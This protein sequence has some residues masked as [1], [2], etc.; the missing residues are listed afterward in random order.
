MA[1]PSQVPFVRRWI[2]RLSVGLKL[3]GAFALVAIVTV[4]LGFF[5]ISQFRELHSAATQLSQNARE[6]SLLGDLNTGVAD[7]QR[8]VNNHILETD[9]ANI[10]KLEAAIGTVRSLSRTRMEEYKGL[11]LEEVDQTLFKEVSTSFDAYEKSIQ[12]VLRY[13]QVNRNREAYR[14]LETETGALFDAL[15]TS[16]DKLLAHNVAANRLATEKSDSGFEGATRLNLTISFILSIVSLIVGFT[17][18]RQNTVRLRGVAQAAEGIARGELDQDVDETGSDEVADLARSF[19]EMVTSLREVATIA[20]QISEGN[21]VQNLEPKS[22]QDQFGVAISTMIIGLRSV[23]TRVRRATDGVNGGARQIAQVSVDLSKATEVQADRARDTSRLMREMAASLKS[24]NQSTQTL[25]RQ[26]ALVDEKSRSLGNA[27]E[28]TAGSL[29]SMAA[30]VESMATKSEL[31]SQA[32]EV[33]AEAASNGQSAIES[34]LEGLTSIDHTM[35]DIRTSIDAL[36]QRSQEIGNILN[37]INDIAEQ[38]NLLALNAAI[39]AARAGEAGRGFAV[40]ADEIRKLAER[41]GKST[42]EIETLVSQ[43]QQ[44]TAQAVGATEK[45]ESAVAT[46]LELGQKTGEALAR[47]LES[48]RNANTL[49]EDVV[50]GTRMQVTSSHDVVQLASQMARYNDEVQQALGTMSKETTQVARA[51]DEQ[52]RGIDRVVAAVQELSE[53]AEA[54]ANLTRQVEQISHELDSEASQL[55]ASTAFFKLERTGSAQRALV[56]KVDQPPR[57]SA[58]RA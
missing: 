8:L 41:S 58:P 23:V 55:Q 36:H 46:G 6:I 24:V 13:S 18:T 57:L 12:Q 9:P 25:A 45:G 10:G 21:L 39:E 5:S 15:N 53:S 56:V 44:V 20:G 14:L 30:V 48:A 7:Y 54:A 49:L 27:V 17:M 19:D 38:T 11:Q 26:V 51:S 40:V 32:S 52:G 33:A 35:D 37:V 2:L 3:I 42:K 22:Q 4:S 47:I 34:T 31:A 50:D 28:K 1:W 29:N 43:I 16:V